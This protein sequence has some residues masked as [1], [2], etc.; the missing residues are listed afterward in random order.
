MACFAEIDE[1]TY[2]VLNVLVVPNEQEHRGQEYL[3]EDCGFGGTWI[4]TSSNT[5]AGVHYNYNTWEP[6]GQP[7]FRKNYAKIGGYYDPVA[8]AFH[9]AKPTQYP[10][11]IL[12]ADTF[13]WKPPIPMP[14]ELP[15]GLA[16]DNYVYIWDESN[17]QWVLQETPESISIFDIENNP[18]KLDEIDRRYK[19]QIEQ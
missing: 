5:R 18:Q 17:I 2:Q 7:A 3:A 13:T 12:D 9:A 15:E 16:S 8:D 6:S 11:F 1:E 4:Q 19:E 14:T 10:S